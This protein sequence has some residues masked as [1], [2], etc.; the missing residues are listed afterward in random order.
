MGKVP[1]VQVHTF[2]AF[3]LRPHYARG[4]EA[5]LYLEAYNE[6][7][8]EQH[9]RAG[10]RLLSQ[11]QGDFSVQGEGALS[12]HPPTDETIRETVAELKRRLPEHVA[13]LC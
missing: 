6:A 8:R 10:M 1:T 9:R 7:V 2:G 12:I 4:S 11:A 13:N 5:I 3:Y